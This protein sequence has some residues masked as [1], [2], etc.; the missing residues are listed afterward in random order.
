MKLCLLGEEGR[1][2]HQNRHNGGKYGRQHEHQGQGYG[3]GGAWGPYSKH[4]H[5]DRTTT[6]QMYDIGV[7]PPHVAGWDVHPRARDL[8]CKLYKNGFLGGRELH[9]TCLDKLATMGEEHI[10]AAIDDLKANYSHG[11]ATI[12]NLGAWLVSTSAGH[13]RNASGGH[14]HQHQGGR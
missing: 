7:V 2:Q 4:R 12:G 8:L 9:A 10:V 11:I 6:S 3:E 1:Q 5:L 13:K 14:G